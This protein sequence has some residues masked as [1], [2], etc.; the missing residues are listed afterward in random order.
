MNCSFCQF[1]TPTVEA[2]Q[3]R[4]LGPCFPPVLMTINMFVGQSTAQTGMDATERAKNIGML[5][6][7]WH[8]VASLLRFIETTKIIT[9]YGS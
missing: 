2:F 6:V 8:F 7:R 4:H 1:I 9:G 3:E 5:M